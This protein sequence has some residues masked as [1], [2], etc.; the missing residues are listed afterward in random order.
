MCKG[1]YVPVWSLGFTKLFWNAII[2]ENTS[3]TVLPHTTSKGKSCSCKILGNKIYLHVF[4]II[5]D[6]WSFTVKLL[7]FLEMTKGITAVALWGAYEFLCVWISPSPFFTGN[8][9]TLR[10]RSVCCLQCFLDWVPWLFA[11]EHC[12]NYG[13]NLLFFWQKYIFTIVLGSP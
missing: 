8:R 1:F 2:T 7:K 13:Q 4:I 10:R 3:N 5:L 9:S 12:G 6:W 11:V